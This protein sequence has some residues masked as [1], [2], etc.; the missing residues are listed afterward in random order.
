MDRSRSRI[1]E[2]DALRG[3]AALSVVLFH[4]TT[5]FQELHPIAAKP[6]AYFG[7]GR[8]GVQ[9][10]FVISGWVILL[11]AR[12]A[13]NA[14]QFAC[15]RAARIYP[16]YVVG[17]MITAA[18]IA[19]VGLP[20]VRI[21]GLTVAGNLLMLQ[22]FVGIPHVDGAYWSLVV[23][24][25]FYTGIAALRTANDLRR[26]DRIVAVWLVGSVAA[27]LIHPKLA[28]LV[29]ILGYGEFFA[30]GMVLG[31]VRA[32]GTSWRGRGLLA[33]LIAFH[34]WSN[35]LE[36]TAVFGVIVGV[37]YAV[38]TGRVRYVP[39]WLA[40]VGSISYP[41][42]LLHQNLGY[43]ALRGFVGMGLNLNVAIGLTI[44]AAL[45]AARQLSRSVE[46]PVSD[47][48]RPLISQLGAARAE[49]EATNSTGIEAMRSA[50]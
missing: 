37:G 15:A 4:Y 43:V 3:I 24:L 6:V 14:L 18:V 11:S 35:G 40:W 23:E 47:A 30:A 25:A 38:A 34:A 12:R 19:L 49:P 21:T 13:G 8:Y 9:L 17:M 36:S 31:D 45:A 32:S 28:L 42:Y 1:S 46:V 39:V 16:A 48:L 33:A 5:R 44:A 20:G 2:L 50:A 7:L 41:L 29:T 27:L 26:V 10:F 22:Q